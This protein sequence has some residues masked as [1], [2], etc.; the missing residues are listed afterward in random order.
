MASKKK[1]RMSFEEGMQALEGVIA[2]MSDGSLSL[3][4]S[5]KAYEEGAALCAQLR[6]M[7]SEHKKRIEQIDPQTA[8][9]TAFEE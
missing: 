2:A 6:N 3:E 5:I 1:Q 7:L 9:I 8:E 4:E